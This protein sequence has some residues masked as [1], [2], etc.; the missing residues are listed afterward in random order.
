MKYLNHV[1]MVV[2]SLIQMVLQRS[3]DC[4]A[5]NSKV[6]YSIELYSCWEY[7]TRT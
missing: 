4:L 2:I 3:V 1:R 7:F 5:N 6:S